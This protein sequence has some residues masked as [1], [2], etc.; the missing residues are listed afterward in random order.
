MRD[1]H[2]KLSLLPASTSTKNQKELGS[3]RPASSSLAET[4]TTKKD[5][6]GQ[7][8]REGKGGQSSAGSAGL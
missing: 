2:R 1:L 5:E 8:L 3:S 7:E 4:R 6:K